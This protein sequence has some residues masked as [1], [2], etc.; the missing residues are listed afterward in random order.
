MDGDFKPANG[1]ISVNQSRAKNQSSQSVPPS[2]AQ[3]N[4]DVSSIKPQS[5]DVMRE[6]MV[7]IKKNTNIKKFHPLHIFH[8]TI[9]HSLLEK[10]NL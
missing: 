8:L 1:E 9:L 5:D 7:M 3:V 6:R 4:S 10:F 2:E